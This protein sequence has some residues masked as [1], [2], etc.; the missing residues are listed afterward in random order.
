ML[1][2]MGS[3]SIGLEHS[4]RRRAYLLAEGRGDGS[5]GAAGACLCVGALARALQ[6]LRLLRHK[7]LLLRLGLRLRGR[8]ELGQV[9]GG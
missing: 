2:T 5:L 7:V 1:F 6:R 3:A 9:R 8:H 4:Q